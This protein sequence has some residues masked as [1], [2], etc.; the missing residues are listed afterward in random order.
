MKFKDITHIFLV[1]SIMIYVCVNNFT[2][3]DYDKKKT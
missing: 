2:T 1:I 3:K